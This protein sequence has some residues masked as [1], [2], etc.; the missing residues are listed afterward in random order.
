MFNRKNYA[1]TAGG[2]GWKGLGLLDAVNTGG[3]FVLVGSVVGVET[4]ST[5]F[6]LF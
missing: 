3:G 6:F 1:I 4:E 2:S 5:D